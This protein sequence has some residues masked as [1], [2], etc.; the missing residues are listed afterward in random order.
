L[1]LAAARSRPRLS[2]RMRLSRGGPLPLRPVWTVVV[3][4]ARVDS[5]GCV[6]VCCTGVW[7]HTR[8]CRTTQTQHTTP[9]HVPLHPVPAQRC[10]QY[11]SSSTEQKLD[12]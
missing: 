9:N 3:E 1:R 2:L 6:C 8:R 10:A 11:D 12:V 4:Q 5:M 7:L